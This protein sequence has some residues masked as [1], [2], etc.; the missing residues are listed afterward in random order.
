MGLAPPP[1]Y[2]DLLRAKQSHSSLSEYRGCPLRFAF[3]YLYQ[4]RPPQHAYL[5]FGSSVHEV[6]EADV[7]A[8]IQA[9][10]DGATAPARTIDSLAERFDRVW[11]D[12]STGEATPVAREE[13]HR[14]ARVAFERY[15]DREAVRDAAPVAVEARF[16][17]EVPGPPDA[18]PIRI[19]GA[20]DRIDRHADGTIEIIDYK[21]GRARTPA[22]VDHDDQLTM[23]ALAVADG[24]VRDEATGEPIPAPGIL[25]LFFVEHGLWISTHRT[26]EQLDAM[27]TSIAQTVA[28]MRAGD[29][30][31]TPSEQACGRCDYAALCPERHPGADA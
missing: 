9:R 25:T 13:Y 22:Q 21:T 29:F 28:R 15:L 31:A 20:I 3:R 5:T 16:D 17:F 14:R 12:S 26:A 11:L 19:H 7:R 8:R 1:A 24:D 6:L 10:R 27:R 30:A 23:Y 4:L 18:A 2:A